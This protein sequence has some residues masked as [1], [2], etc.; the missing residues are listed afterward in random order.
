MGN[1]PNKRSQYIPYLC[2]ALL[3][4]LA[5]LL[6]ANIVDALTFNRSGF[7]TAQLWRV[8]SAQLLHTNANHALV[9]IIGLAILW[10]LHGDYINPVRFVLI[11]LILS[12][13]VSLGIYYLTPQ[14]NSYVGLSG[15]LHGLFA[16]GLI[17]DIKLKRR[18][19]YLLLFGLLVKLAQE[20]FNPDNDFMSEFIQAT[21]AVDAHL[22][23]AVIGLALGLFVPIS[24]S[25]K[26][27]YKGQ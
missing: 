1:I 21:V 24:S 20:Q 25:Y 11:F 14:L 10:L 15:V 3:S 4:V 8:F 19:G 18:S 12:V 6:P 5:F 9:N 23:G 16:W 17:H 27:H 22:Y 13:G 2:V 26:R 7:E